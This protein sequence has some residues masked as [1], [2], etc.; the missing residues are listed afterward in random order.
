M[1]ERKWAPPIERCPFCG[2]D[3]LY[4]VAGVLQ[5]VYRCEVCEESALIVPVSVPA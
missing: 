1:S 4:P 3:E 5:D 2:Q